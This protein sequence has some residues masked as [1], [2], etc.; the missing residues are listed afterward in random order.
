MTKRAVV[1]TSM[2]CNI[3]KRIV[4]GQLFFKPGLCQ[5]A[6][7]IKFIRVLLT[8][9]KTVSFKLLCRNRQLIGNRR[10][11]AVFLNKFSTDNFGS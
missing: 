9:R 7:V 2:V 3:Y 5:K 6:A 11:C 10:E 8:K 4:F 1:Y